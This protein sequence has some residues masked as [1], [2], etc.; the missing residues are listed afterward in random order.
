MQLGRAEYLKR[1]YIANFPF[2]FIFNVLLFEKEQMFGVEKM[3]AKEKLYNE[4]KNMSDEAVYKTMLILDALAAQE[5]PQPY[6]QT[7]P[8][9]ASKERLAWE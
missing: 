2:L 4:I 7:C 8:K 1:Y 3:T 9:S 6:G 5:E